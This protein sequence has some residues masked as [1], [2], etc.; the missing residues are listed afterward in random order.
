MIHEKVLTKASANLKGSSE[1]AVPI[2]VV[3]NWEEGVTSP[4]H[5]PVIGCKM[6]SGGCRNLGKSSF[7]P[8]S[9]EVD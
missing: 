8:R 1:T 2:G 4:P 5:Q 7:I 3:L 6:P 9:L